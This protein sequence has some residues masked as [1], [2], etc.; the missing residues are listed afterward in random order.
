[1][2]RILVHVVAV[3]YS[4]PIHHRGVVDVH[5]FRPVDHSRIRYVD[6]GY[7]HLARAIRRHPHIARSQRKP[8][9]SNSGRTAEFDRCRNCSSSNKRY[10]RRRIDRPFVDASNRNRPRHPTPAP[11]RYHS[12]A[13]IMERRKSPRL[14]FHPR[15]TPWSNVCPMSIAIWR[16]IRSDSVRNPHM[17]ILPIVAPRTMIVEI[18]VTDHIR[19]NI[20]RRFEPVFTPVAFHGPFL[21]VIGL[22]QWLLVVAHLVRSGESV[23]LT[24]TSVISLATRSYF[25]RAA[26]N[27]HRAGVAI[28]AHIHTIFAWPQN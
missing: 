16:P 2:W 10:Q 5:H 8:R 4:R 25:S 17:A 21:K 26:F 7:I 20:P 1:M 14:V 18:F 6:P 12:P 19:R 22:R 3:H 9:H 27:V 11:A 24:G 28:R 23:L 13:P 15:P